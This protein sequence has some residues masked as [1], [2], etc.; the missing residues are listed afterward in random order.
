MSGH[1]QLADNFRLLSLF[2]V[3]TLF[4][5]EDLFIL[6]EQKLKYKANNGG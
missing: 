3:D 6:W 1:C 5:E 4:I 2:C